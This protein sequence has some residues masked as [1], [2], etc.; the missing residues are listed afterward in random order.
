MQILTIVGEQAYVFTYGNLAQNF[1][2]DL[3]VL[4]KMLESFNGTNTSP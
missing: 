2:A 1:K 4:E 3:P